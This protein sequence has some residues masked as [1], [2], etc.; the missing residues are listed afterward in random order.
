[1]LVHR[2]PAGQLLPLDPFH[3]AEEQTMSEAASNKLIN[4]SSMA[5]TLVE[6]LPRKSLTQTVIIG[7]DRAHRNFESTLYMA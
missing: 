5:C 3:A 7:H 2:L 1:M 6:S 4:L